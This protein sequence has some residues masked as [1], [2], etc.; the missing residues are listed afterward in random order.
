[1]KQALYQITID[2][3]DVSENFSPI[4]QRLRVHL[5]AEETS[6]TVDIEL[7]DAYG[8]IAL[9][10]DDAFVAVALGWDVWGLVP[11]FEGVVDDIKSRGA[12]GGGTTLS[13]T[14]RSAD[15]KGK[16]KHGQEKSWDDKTLKE[17]MEE[18]AR[19]A[20]FTM[21]IDSELGQIK[22]DWWGMHA[23]SFYHFGHRIA[24]EVG[25]VFKVFG[26]RAVLVKRNGGLS[27]AGMALSSVTATAGEGGNLINWDIS[28]TVGRPRYANVV[29]RWY[30]MKE[31]K[32][33][34][35]KVEIGGDVGGKADN[36]TRF[37][38][39]DQNEAKSAGK[40]GK[41]A[42]DRNKGEGSV[43]IDGDPTATPEGICIVS[44]ARP[45]ID[46]AYRIDN[47]DHDLARN[48]GFTTSL[49]LKQP[50][51]GAGSDSR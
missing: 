23:E 38:E 43:L 15:T 16:G 6:D 40:N 48:D 21:Q 3:I 37:T 11:V 4:L 31:A 44:G 39:G 24:R 17:V 50:Q 14:A 5:A 49:K 1:M 10:S 2:G 20:G 26:K 9:P 18:A 19:E 27:A 29:A 13:I 41:K 45:G 51:D 28:P 32:W 42:S 47:V 8:R 34:Q 7:D 22:R 25:G 33:K 12:R 46:G 30:D 35:E 36:Y